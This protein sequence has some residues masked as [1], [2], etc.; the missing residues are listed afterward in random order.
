MGVSTQTVFE[1][2]GSLLSLT[3]GSLLNTNILSGGSGPLQAEIRD[4]DGF[5]SQ[6]DDGVSSLT[7][8]NGDV[9]EG[10]IDYIG[11]GTMATIG[12]LGIQLDSRPVAAF[13]VDGQI[14]LIAP[15]GFPLL[16]GLSIA[17]D[18]DPNAPFALSNFAPCYLEGTL[19]LTP[20]GPRPIEALKA[21][22]MVVD[23]R[24]TPHDILW[25]GFRNAVER[26]KD[27][28]VRVPAGFFGPSVPF[29]D[30]YVSQQHRIAMYLP[31]YGPRPVFARAKLL[32]D[33]GLE[34]ARG[35]GEIT[36]HH[37][38]FEKHIVLIANGMPAES[39]RAA[40][41]ARQAYGAKVW[42]EIL[43]VLPSAAEACQELAL[44]EIRRGELQKRRNR[45][46]RMASDL[47][48]QPWQQGGRSPDQPRIIH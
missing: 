5:L 10:A 39:L 27:I 17:F 40:K 23:H 12:L 4:N 16:S 6:G 32:L 34:L 26:E 9:V 11:S 41:G 24:G 13:S 42:Q 21:G 43:E 33:E 25:H 20:D 37:L 45:T 18:I 19:I 2:N 1:Y 44:R 47:S 35:L 36:Y 7:L 22:D 31:E 46:R 48:G 14:Y 3:A 15:N 29:A 30:T 38:L 8:A 28:P